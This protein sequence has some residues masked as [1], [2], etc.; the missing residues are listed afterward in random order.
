MGHI[1]PVNSVDFANGNS[2]YLVTSGRDRAVKIWHWKSKTVKLTVDLRKHGRGAG[3]LYSNFRSVHDT[4]SSQNLCF[5]HWAEIRKKVQFR[6]VMTLLYY[7]TILPF[8]APL[9]C[10]Y[11]CTIWSKPKNLPKNYHLLVQF[12]QLEET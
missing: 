3:L 10:E 2:D 11:K 5:A 9:I 8:L 4:I 6:Y 7:C 1:A 12:S